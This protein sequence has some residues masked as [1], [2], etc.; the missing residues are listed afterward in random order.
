M[1]WEFVWTKTKSSQIPSLLPRPSRKA[2]LLATS[3]QAEALSGSPFWLGMDGTSELVHIE[4]T[5]GTC[6]SGSY[7]QHY[8][9]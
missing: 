7:L 8:T 4:H 5:I 6:R 9:H 1:C 2:S 3:V